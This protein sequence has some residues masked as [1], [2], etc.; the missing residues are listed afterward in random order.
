MQITV[1]PAAEHEVDVAAAVLGEAFATDPVL[2][3][4]RPP[5]PDEDRVAVLGQLFAALVRAVPAGSRALDVAVEA[6]GRVVGAAF[7]E[8]PRPHPGGTIAFV[9]QLPALL[10]VFG[11]VGG[12]SAL[13]H[14]RRTDRVRPEA[15][16][17]YLLGIGVA[18]VARGQ[19]VGG[20]LL[21]HALD[22]VDGQAQHAYL[23]SSTPVNRRLYRRHGFGDGA[24]VPG[25]RSAAPIA[26][27]R[28]AVAP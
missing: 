20:L 7:W 5:R 25:F 22:R 1:R 28:P 24:P 13:R 19:G 17:W 14:L 6:G 26:M 16:H 23:E 2:A 12:L 10:G 9:R 4:F 15:P 18:P 21:E 3:E 8:A 11:V 27:W